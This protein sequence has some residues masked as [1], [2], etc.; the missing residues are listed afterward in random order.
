M[1]DQEHPQPALAGEGCAEE[2]GRAGA[3]DDSVEARRR[4][5]RLCTA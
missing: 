1:V 4:T 3:D 5:Q 2:A